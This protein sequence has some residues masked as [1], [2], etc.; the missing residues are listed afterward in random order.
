MDTYRIRI[1]LLMHK[2]A[3][4]LPNLHALAEAAS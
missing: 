4:D 3:V 2:P 1:W